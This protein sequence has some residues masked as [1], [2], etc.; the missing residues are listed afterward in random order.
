[1]F[2]S[3]LL[4]E[5]IQGEIQR[6]YVCALDG[7]V[8]GLKVRDLGPQLSQL[9]L[10]LCCLDF[11]LS[12]SSFLTL[13]RLIGSLAVSDDSLILSLLLLLSSLGSLSRRKDNLEV[14]NR[15]TPCFPLLLARLLWLWCGIVGGRGGSD[16]TRVIQVR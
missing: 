13:A 7:A 15:L 2:T 3:R 6:W 4:R 12:Y 5:S 1:M 16:N 14:W 10:H 11:K 8:F 9:S